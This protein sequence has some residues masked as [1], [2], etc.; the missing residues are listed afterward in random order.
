MILSIVQ[1]V[2]EFVLTKKCGEKNIG[3]GSDGS[4]GT[5]LKL[6]RMFRRTTDIDLSYCILR[7]ENAE[8]RAT[9]RPL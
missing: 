9:N 3:M 8:K 6:T 4:G 1:Y 5:V 2:Y 7:S